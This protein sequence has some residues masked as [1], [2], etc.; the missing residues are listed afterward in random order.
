MGAVNATDANSIATLFRF[1][2]V[3]LLGKK[4]QP[5]CGK[6]TLGMTI[7]TNVEVIVPQVIRQTAPKKARLHRPSSQLSRYVAQLLQPVRPKIGRSPR[8]YLS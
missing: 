7:T 4:A 3:L 5:R 6:W 8:K 1:F 2:M